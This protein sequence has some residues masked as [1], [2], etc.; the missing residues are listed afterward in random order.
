MKAVLAIAIQTARSSIRS[1]VF[2]ILLLIIGVATGL[3]PDSVMGDATLAGEF[4]IR[5][6][7]SIGIITFLTGMAALWVGTVNIAGEVEGYQIHMVVT[8]P[9][10]NFQ[11]W[12]GKFLGV[13]T[14]S[15]VILY[16]SSA[17]IYWRIDSEVEAIRSELVDKS[18]RLLIEAKEKLNDDQKQTL[19]EPVNFL[20]G[21]LGKYTTEEERSFFKSLKNIESPEKETVRSRLLPLVKKFREFDELNDEVLIGRNFYSW[22]RPDFTQLALER[23]EKGMASL[24]R[25]NFDDSK[26]SM[27]IKEMAR[28]LE[29]KAGSLPPATANQPQPTP[30]IF[31][32]SN[33]PE[34]A[35]DVPVFIRLRLF[36]GDSLDQKPRNTM[37]GFALVDEEQK[38]LG[39]I[40]PVGLK[41]TEFY[42]YRIPA[43]ALQ[44]RQTLGVTIFNYDHMG[45]RGNDTKPPKELVIQAKDGPYILIGQTSFFSNYWRCILLV[46]LFIAFLVIVGTATGLCFSTPV[47]VMLSVSYIIIGVGISSVLS[48]ESQ[49]EV[50]KVQ[51]DTAKEYEK[52]GVAGV[53]FK[54]LKNTMV[55]AETFSRMESVSSGRSIDWPLIIKVFLYD[56]ILKGLPL[57]LLGLYALHRRELGLVVRK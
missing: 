45:R 10:S 3:L 25:D 31:M 27:K 21:Y 41:T 1:K 2:F 29:S 17:Y 54:L 8:K 16:T 55:S 42:S 22:Q 7:Y 5:I 13:A 28:A 34:V 50:E 24:G 30:K 43:A 44:K 56:F 4:K 48:T 39:Q 49:Y 23:I 47:A 37:I 6:N 51:G 53:Y 15:L 19:A 18:G 38:P 12:F 32:F 14:L 9:V 33:L 26:M 36:A 20:L 57:I 46:G 52:G 35:E 11:L 40:L